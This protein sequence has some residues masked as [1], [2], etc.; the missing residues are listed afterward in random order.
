MLRVVDTTSS[1]RV[2]YGTCFSLQPLPF[3]NPE[4][5][6]KLFPYSPNQVHISRQNSSSG[7]ILLHGMWVGVHSPSLVIPILSQRHLLVTNDP[8]MNRSATWALAG[9][10]FLHLCGVHTTCPIWQSPIIHE[11]SCRNRDPAQHSGMIPA[12]FH[13]PGPEDKLFSFVF[14]FDIILP[15][16]SH[17]RAVW[18]ELCVSF[19]GL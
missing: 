19:C 5:C 4:C 10:A 2:H 9:R 15:L 12:I 7:G 8:T 11:M 6:S 13:L 17:F 1:S 16:C 3:K 18:G 14:Y